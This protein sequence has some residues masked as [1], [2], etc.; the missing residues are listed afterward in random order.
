MAE[1]RYLIA[2]GSNQRHHRHGGPEQVLTAA[3]ASLDSE[4]LAIDATAPIRG[5]APIGPSRRRYANAAAIIRTH[6]DPPALLAHLKAIERRFGRRPGGQRWRARVLDLDIILWSGG[7]FT[8]RTLTV[9]HA[10]FRQRDFVLAPARAIA[11][12]WRD[13]K[14]GLTIRH[15]AHRLR[16]AS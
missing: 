7:T 11:D 2:L 16:R 9:P 4:G 13:P 8:A 6:L 12:T 1:H 15:L 10:A 14:T 5:S 3:F